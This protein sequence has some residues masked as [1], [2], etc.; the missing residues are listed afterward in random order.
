MSGDMK[1]ARAR[2]EAFLARA[3][4]AEYRDVILKIKA[5]LAAMP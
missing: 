3:S 5:E 4:P 1:Q 2:F